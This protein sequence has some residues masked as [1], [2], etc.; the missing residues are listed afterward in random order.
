MEIVFLSA[1]AVGLFIGYDLYNDR[2]QA[3]LER[4][5]DFYRALAAQRLARVHEL[6]DRIDAAERHA[7]DAQAV[8]DAV[9][10]DA[11]ARH[12]VSRPSLRVLS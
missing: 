6:L 5:L 3:R 10:S 11:I 4:T 1:V 7:Q 12:P 9:V 8:V 2:R